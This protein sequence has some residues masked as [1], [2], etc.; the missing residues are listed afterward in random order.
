MREHPDDPAAPKTR[1]M[2]GACTSTFEGGDKISSLRSPVRSVSVIRY[3]QV[4]ESRATT[5]TK[6]PTEYSR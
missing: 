2:P 6:A 4:N 3:E 1:R 5:R